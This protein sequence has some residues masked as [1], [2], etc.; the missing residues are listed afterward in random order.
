MKIA[1]V[2]LAVGLPDE[3][4][5]QVL[6]RCLAGVLK[7]PLLIGLAGE[8]GTGKTTL[9]RALIQTLVPD[10]RVK[11]PTYTLVESYVSPVAELHHLDLY[12]L[13]DPAEL[14]DLGIADLLTDD[15]I[16][17][18][19]WPEKGAGH[20]PPLDILVSLG[21]ANPGRT[22][23][24]SATSQTGRVVLLALQQVLGDEGA[25]GNSLGESEKR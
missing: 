18:V 19:E 22:L 10:T 21:H 12:R 1:P 9:V 4:A 13:R 3:A 7:T 23:A 2:L 15:A 8:L 16:L 24:I 20:L 17:L 14:D 25:L 5:T 11:S 6:G